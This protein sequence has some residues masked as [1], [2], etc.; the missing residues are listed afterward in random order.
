MKLKDL[1]KIIKK[2][3]EW[4]A[5]KQYKTFTSTPERKSMFHK[6]LTWSTIK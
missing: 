4:S 2:W 5:R 6:I 3:A 1:K